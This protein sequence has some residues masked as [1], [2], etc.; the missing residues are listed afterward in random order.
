MDALFVLSEIALDTEA[1]RV[2]SQSLIENVIF[3]LLRPVVV[4]LENRFSPVSA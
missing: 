4:T 2:A 1:C 3:L